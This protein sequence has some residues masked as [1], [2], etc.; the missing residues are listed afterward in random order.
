MLFAVAILTLSCSRERET[1]ITG[2]VRIAGTEKA[3]AHTPVTMVIYERIPGSGPQSVFN[4]RAIA[5]ATS[6]ANANFT[7][8]ARLRRDG[9]YFLGLDPERSA[10]LVDLIAP[11]LGDATLPE[12][13]ITKIGGTVRMN[14]YLYGY[15]WARIR[16]INDNFQPG[17]GIWLI[18]QGQHSGVASADVTHLF[19]GIGNHYNTIGM[20]IYSQGAYVK[21]RTEMVFVP[22]NDTVYQEIRWP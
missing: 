9:E 6:D 1:T 15:G 7:I 13:R 5:E 12:R 19:R 20:S 10:E 14:Y 4:V 3:I 11:T 17:D 21:N 2:Q 8:T 16:F 18:F 22:Y